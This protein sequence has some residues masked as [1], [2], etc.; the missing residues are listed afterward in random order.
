M[1]YLI[2]WEDDNVGE[3][4]FSLH[5]TVKDVEKKYEKIVRL[6]EVSPCSIDVFVVSRKLEPHVKFTE[7]ELKKGSKKDNIK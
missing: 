6:D 5:P 4:G 3:Y 2:I 7:T 1:K